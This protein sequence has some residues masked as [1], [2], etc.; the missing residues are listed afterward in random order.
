M[1]TPNF[2]MQAI[3]PAS[4]DVGALGQDGPADPRTPGTWTITH[5]DHVPIHTFTAPEDG[6][7]VTSHIIE[8]PSQVLVIDAQYT[9]TYAREVARRAC[10]LKKP[11]TRLYVTHYHPD[12][13]LGAAAFDAPLFALASVA[14]KITA[15]GDRVAHEE[16]EKV[17]EDVPATARRPDRRIDE[18]EEVIDGVRIQYRRLQIA[19]T[20]DALIIALPDARA[21]VVQDLVYNHSHLF[22]G[23]Q[24]FDGWR[25]ALRQYRDLPYDFVLP[26]HGVPGGKVLFDEMIE[27]LDF[28]E[29]AL[30]QSATA[31]EFK[32][33]ILKRYPDY[34]CGKVLDHQLRF[35][36]R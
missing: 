32:Q 27:Y 26:G 9:L 24:H 19:E 36:F 2:A 31:A 3:E 28:A 35:L 11:L 30:N 21:I 14:E 12:H 1:T 22:L 8:L 29:D 34:G 6:W 25:A 10:A 4:G 20:E 23:E 16:H 5:N 15:V 13:L 33:R 18:G 17:G 7:L